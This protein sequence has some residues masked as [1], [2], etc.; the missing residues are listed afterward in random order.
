M[1]FGTYL[2]SSFC[3]IRRVMARKMKMKMKMKRTRTRMR[4][5]TR[6]VM[7]EANELFPDL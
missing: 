5:R 2:N 6:M 7:S 4:M 3:R 1:S